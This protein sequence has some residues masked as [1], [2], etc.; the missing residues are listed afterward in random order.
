M[1]RPLA[2]ETASLW[3]A[4]GDRHRRLHRDALHLSG[5]CVKPGRHIGGNNRLAGIIDLFDETS[6]GWAHRSMSADA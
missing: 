5:V 3:R 2:H 6:Q 4:E 1:P